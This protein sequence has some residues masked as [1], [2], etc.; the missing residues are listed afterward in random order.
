MKNNPV[1]TGGPVTGEKEEQGG[2]SAS[3]FLRNSQKLEIHNEK[4]FQGVSPKILE[5]HKE[6]V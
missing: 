5:S 2:P 1:R 4:A 6:E 3:Q